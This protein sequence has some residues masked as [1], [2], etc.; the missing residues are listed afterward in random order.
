MCHISHV[1]IRALCRGNGPCRG[2]DNGTDIV[3]LLRGELMAARKQWLGFVLWPPVHLARRKCVLSPGVA[4]INNTHW[5]S[6]CG[7]VGHRCLTNGCLLSKGV[8]PLYLLP[9]ISTSCYSY[10]PL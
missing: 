6:R 4:S 5:C 3:S 9:V 2:V 7:R 10:F 8:F 1:S